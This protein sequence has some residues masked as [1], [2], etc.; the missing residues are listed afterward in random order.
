MKLRVIFL[1]PILIFAQFQHIAAEAAQTV[2]DWTIPAIYGLDRCTTAQE[3]DCIDSVALISD[4]GSVEPAEFLSFEATSLRSSQNGNTVIPGAT[5]W[6]AKGKNIKLEVQLE[7]PNH[8]IGIGPDG[9]KLTGA[10]LRAIIVVADPLITKVRAKVRTSWLK[11]MNVQLKMKD[12]DFSQ[13]S[14]AGGNLWTIEGKGTTLSDYSGDWLSVPEKKSFNAKADVENPEFSFIIHHAGTD[15]R[16]S[17][18]APICAD[19]GYT[20]QSHNTN[21]TGDPT[22][23]YKDEYLEFAISSPHLKSDGTLNEGYF[24]FWTTHQF[25]DCKFPGNTLTKYTKLILQI[26]Y[27]DGT[28][29]IATTSVKNS[30]GKLSFSATGFHFSSPKIV[31]KVDLSAS[32]SPTPTPIVS[33]TPTPS[34]TET[35]PQTPEVTPSPSPTPAKSTLVVAAKK[36]TITCTKGKLVK[37]V[38]AVNPKCPVGYKKK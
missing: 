31:L 19:K 35:A 21:A 37:K 16:S 36:T 7:T 32:P 26:V 38:S 34:P 15:A 20:V 30:D 24:R 1:T 33:A 23:N 25:L 9:T 5:L 13:Q 11:P 17:Y 6:K 22:W 27:E 2:K 18:W 3:L 10:A 29:T 8:V 14:I 12:A 4:D 28:S